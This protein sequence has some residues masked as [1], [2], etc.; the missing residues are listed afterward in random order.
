MKFL[1]IENQPDLSQFGPFNRCRV[2]PGL[3]NDLGVNYMI[4]NPDHLTKLPEGSF[5]TIANHP[6]G[7]LDGVIL[8]DLMAGLRPVL[9]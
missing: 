2:Y 5:I 4:G 7:G 1:A 3:L 6:Y 8:I 9:G